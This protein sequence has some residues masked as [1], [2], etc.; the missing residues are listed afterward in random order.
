MKCKQCKED[1]GLEVL[2]GV[3]IQFN[4]MEFCCIPCADLYTLGE[5]YKDVV[6]LR[7][8]NQGSPVLPSTKV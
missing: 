3:A 4:N 1:I 2:A 5:K 7:K 6:V 8:E